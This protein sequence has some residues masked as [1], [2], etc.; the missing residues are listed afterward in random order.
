M[1]STLTISGEITDEDQLRLILILITTLL[2][3]ECLHQTT[4]TT[5]TNL[6]I[7]F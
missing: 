1:K 7:S 4:R 3:A 2:M 6:M 5:L